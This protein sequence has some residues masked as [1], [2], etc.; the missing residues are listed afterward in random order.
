LHDF[1][2]MA[3]TLRQRETDN[4]RLQQQ[5]QLSLLNEQERATR[6][7][8]TG[9]RNHRYFQE[10]L[11][12]ELDRSRRAG[13]PVSI[14]MLD[15]DN[16][17]QVNDR[18]GHHEGDAVLLRV[19]QGITDNLRPYDLACR[20]GGEEFGIIFPGTSAE[21]AV[22]VLQRIAEHIISF[23]PNGERATFSGGVSTFPEHAA[24]PDTLFKFSDEAAYTAKMNGKNQVVVY[25]P[26]SVIEMNS[27]EHQRQR[28]RDAALQTATTLV[29]AVDAKD[30]YA[31]HHSE[32]TAIYAAT[33]ARAYRMDEETVKRV[34]RAA[35]LHD[36]GKIGI[37]D[38]ILTKPGRLTDAEYA[39][40][41]MHPEFSFRILENAGLGDIATFVRHHH[42]HW[43]GSGYPFGLS[44]EQIPLESRI[45]LVADAFEAM[46]SDR[47][48]RRSL[49]MQQAISE[50][51]TYGG[52]QFDPQV[53][54]VMVQLV[55]SGVFD[56]VR[57]Q[58]GKAVEEVHAPQTLQ[59]QTQAPPPEAPQAPQQPAA[60][61]PAPQ[62]PP[63]MP[64]PA[65]PS[66]GS[67][68]A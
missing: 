12:A 37:A 57:A 49:G 4:E 14:A 28:S 10:S 39:Q 58:Y 38:H 17:K 68:A 26:S 1:N 45:I 48:Y 20:L 7:P 35:L 36:V 42:E 27:D 66:D 53:A 50:L 65:F 21:D 44:G 64:P 30:P 47:V 41:K 23:G 2:F 54:D 51:T 43:D 60:Q 19:T 55:L 5:L 9:L 8:L 52:T 3:R 11:R 16:F 62:P 22:M 24:D 34:Y 56:Q 40:V 59:P 25:D 61:D 6:D 32:L 18:F 33:I 29:T 46:T 13:T 63:Q 67:A 15:L 31:R